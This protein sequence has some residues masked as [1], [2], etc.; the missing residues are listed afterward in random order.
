MSNTF[1]LKERP[2]RKNW[3][4]Y[5]TDSNG[6]PQWASTGTR[7][8]ALAG[9]FLETFNRLHAPSC[10]VN[11]GE[12]LKEYTRQHYQRTAVSMARHNSILRVL[13]PL[14]DCDPL[15]HAAFKSAVRAWKKERSFSVKPVTLAREM[16]VLIAAINWA[17][18]DEKGDMLDGVPYIPKNDYK[19][20]ARVR[21]LD[22]DEKKVLL[23]VLQ[24]EPLHLKLAVGIAISTAS[25]QTAILELQKHQ[26]KWREGQIDFN[27]PNDGK[28]RKARRVCDITGL[29]EAWLREA[30]DNSVTGH[31]IEKDGYPV[32]NLYPDFDKFRQKTGIQNFRFHD[33]RSTWAAGAALAGVP[34]E[35][36]RDALGHSTVMMTE[37][38]Y[39]Q[40]HPDYRAAARDY[41]KKTFVSHMSAVS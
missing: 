7:D 14:H 18:D 17:A 19:K 41:A 30:Y 5:W 4:I 33:L 32:T 35:Q 16:S 9:K 28:R 12:I 21:W 3:Y 39:A 25:R 11:V 8:E 23:D 40:I 27:P 1:E 38:H 26:I 36:I 20:E 22:E 10:I 24:T 6:K 31:I 2:D 29:V 37:K 15:D 34:M 13:K